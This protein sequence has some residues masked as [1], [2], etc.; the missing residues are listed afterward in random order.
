M[1]ELQE[2]S[3]GSFDNPWLW[4]T[5]ARQ[6]AKV[7]LCLLICC[8]TGFGALLVQ[9]V[10]G[11]VILVVSTGVLLLAMGAATMNSLQETAVDGT[12]QRTSERP[13]VRKSVSSKFALCQAVCLVACGLALLAT[14]GGSLLPLLLGILSLVLYNGV[15][16]RL[17]QRTVLALL[18]GAVC[19]GLPP[20]I[21]WIG[22][23]GRPLSYMSLLLFVLL[24]LWQI[25]HFCLI[26]LQHR[27]DYLHAVQPSFLSLL[28]EKSVR[29]IST[30]WICGLAL[31][32]MLFSI[33]PGPI[34]QW[35]Q[36]LLVINAMGL[37]AGTIYS[38]LLSRAVTYRSLFIFL[39]LMLF[40]H[41][42]ILSMGPVLS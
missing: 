8:S 10:S 4:F 37:A 6:L 36:I 31:V 2:Q 34:W 11:E 22:A 12:M 5:A 7:P 14:L 29:Q 25:P 30:V 19:G 1:S 9:D 32:M 40:S 42:A 21:G 24:F 41:M 33:T 27:E 28:S 39:N 35:Q 17:K 38:L 26:L 18:P 23:G 16:T 3:P 20:L 15:Y 13:L